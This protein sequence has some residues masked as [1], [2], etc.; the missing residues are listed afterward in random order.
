MFSPRLIFRTTFVTHEQIMLQY[1]RYFY[2]A[3]RPCAA[4]FPYNTQPGAGGLAGTDKNA[5]ADRRHH[6]VLE[7]RTS[8]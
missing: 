1:S 2:D 7:T 3:S 8:P 6:L 5:F 4:Q